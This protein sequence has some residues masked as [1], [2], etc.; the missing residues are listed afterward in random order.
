MKLLPL[1]L[2]VFLYS[3]ASQP[4]QMNA[5]PVSASVVT[6]NTETTTTQNDYT[7]S[8]EGKVN[9]E[10]RP[11]VEGYLEKI[12]V[13][14]GAYVQAG[15]PLFKINDAPFREQ[16][17]SAK[18]S[19]QSAEAAM[20]NAQLEID[21]LSPLVQ[22]KVVSDVQLKTAKATYK[23]AQAN[24]AQAGALVSAAQ[25]NLGY[26]LIK[27]PVSGYIGR[28]PKKQGA[29]ISRSDPEAMTTLS[30][31]HEVYAYFSLSENDF[32]QFKAHYPGKTLEEKLKALPPV[33]LLL[34]D[35][36]LYPVS[37]KIDMIDGQFNKSTGAIT[38]RA[39]FDN[40]EG[41]IR[42]G[43][44]GKI[45]LSQQHQDAI[46]VPQAATL[47]IQDK[48]FVFTVGADNKVAKQAV[49]ISG[50]NGSNYLVSE[51][52]KAGD[53]IV[54]S[55]LDHLQEGAVIKPE[56]MKETAKLSMNK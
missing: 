24:A 51:G 54:Y 38:L 45:R 3:C 4:A 40:K 5:G 42:S 27:A 43:N 44:T 39:V 50:K 1:S 2:L 49:V 28:L 22:N 12:Y 8:I 47:E 35:N 17:N 32:V 23:A 31:V 18:A 48:V 20:L 30:D 14:E 55:G 7:A 33:G 21:K 11:Q 13:D 29:L 16:I 37:G 53:R 6:I 46:L 56:T 15:Q 10:I 52:V 26:T 34:S 9:V 19:L 36:T 41:L 25:I